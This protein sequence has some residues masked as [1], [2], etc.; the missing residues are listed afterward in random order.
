MEHKHIL[1][2]AFPMQDIFKERGIGRYTREVVRSVIRLYKENHDSIQNVDCTII[3]A[4]NKLNSEELGLDVQSVAN[5]ADVKVKS[6]SSTLHF[7]VLDR[8]IPTDK[9]LTKDIYNHFYAQAVIRNHIKELNKT[10]KVYYFMP[11]HQMPMQTNTYRNI[12]MVHDI[13]PILFNRFSS[14]IG[15][16]IIKKRQYMFY[17]DQLNRMDLII[18]NT[19]DTAKSLTNVLKFPPK[20]KSIFLGIPEHFSKVTRSIK[21][22]FKFDSKYFIYYGGYDDNKNIEKIFEL[23]SG[24]IVSTSEAQNINLLLVGGEKVKG[25]LLELAKRYRIESN[26]K[27]TKYLSDFELISAIKGS[28]GLFRLSLFEGFGLPELESMALGVPV[29]SSNIPAVKEVTKEYAFLFDPK[30]PNKEELFRVMKAC[31]NGRIDAKLLKE[32]SNYANG[33]TW[34]NNTVE[35]INAICQV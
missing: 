9:H 32:A 23:F 28:L 5:L 11:H 26:V 2:N 20:T 24:F 12:V 16:S 17:I 3:L 8:E 30:N 6:K 10:F 1:I 22:E 33:K 29:I 14:F 31:I 19:E 34:K 13:I 4:K 25:R 18:T 7:F 27:L 21:D 35:L 15:L